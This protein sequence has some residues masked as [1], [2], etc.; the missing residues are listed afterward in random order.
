MYSE[1]DFLCCW[2]PAAPEKH[3]VANFALNA[4]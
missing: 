2:N 1:G 4:A 3:Q